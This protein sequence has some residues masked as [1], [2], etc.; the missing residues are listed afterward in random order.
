[1]ATK[2]TAL[3]YPH[4]AIE[5][6]G[7]IKNALFLWDN[8]DLICPFGDL[9][10]MPDDP[11]VRE[12]FQAIARP[13]QPSH[14]EKQSAHDAI[15]EIANSNLPD[16]F[17]PERVNEDLRYTI[18]P[19]KLLP[20]TW[21][22]LQDTKLARPI[23]GYIDPPMPPSAI[24]TIFEDAKRAAYET[25]HAFGLTMLS[26][27]AD[28][29]AGETRQLVTD[30]IDSYVALNDYLKLVGGAKPERTPKAGYDR[31]VTLSLSVLDV[32]AV[33][34][35]ALVAMRE[36]EKKRPELRAMRHAYLRKLDT[37]VER[38]RKE[39]R[40]SRDVTE[41]ERTFGRRSRTI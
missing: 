30:E 34:L 1:M 8:V 10:R 4:I 36:S 22:A 39:A 25:T 33:K 23:V 37:Y 12:A 29:C 15:I 24:K 5:N 27:I 40:N 11:D 9:P 31:L 2:L 19:E 13:L 38:L 26:I 28:C 6:K 17:F 16:W 41:I 20:A 14:E 21:H 32:S 3:Y 7:L 18:H 35:P